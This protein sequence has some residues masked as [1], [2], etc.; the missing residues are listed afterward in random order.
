MDNSNNNNDNI[1]L[2]SLN[3]NQ[4]LSEAISKQ[5]NVP[6]SC[7]KISRFADGEVQLDITDSIRNDIVF[8]IQS[9]SKPVNE[10]LMELLIFIDAIKRA[11]AKEINVVMPY[12]GYARQDRKSKSRQ[13]ISAKL[14]ANLLETAG[15]DRVITI[16]LHASQIQGFFN[17]PTDHL[18]SDLPIEEYI[19]NNIGTDNLVIVSP[20]HGGAKRADKL[21]KKLGDLPLAII[22]KRRPAPN[23]VEVEHLIGDV[24]GKKAI[25][26]D[27]MVDTAGTLTAGAQALMDHGAS[28]VYAVCVHGVLSDPAL[29]R[30]NDS[31]IKKLVVTDTIKQ[32]KHS[33]KID[34][35][36]VDKILATAIRNV[37]EGKSMKD[38]FG[39][40]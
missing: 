1:R 7:C 39:G 17:I 3:S 29:E 21:S 26:V 31:V 6:L 10:N 14:V 4:E 12:Y 2:F 37:Y 5:L 8:L 25:I 30:I 16:D 27:D 28:E 11:S 15:A 24:K 20:D 23:E 38:L 35:V 36:S 33:D 9:T 34:V 19:V 18:K 22:D 13:P 32:T 40:N